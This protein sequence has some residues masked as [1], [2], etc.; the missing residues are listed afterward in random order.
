MDQYIPKLGDTNQDVSNKITALYKELTDTM[1][2]AIPEGTLIPVVQ[3]STGLSG[4]IPIEE[5][6]YNL[7][8]IK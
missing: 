6:D 5:F 7:Y 1:R 2:N 4:K 8:S 3:K